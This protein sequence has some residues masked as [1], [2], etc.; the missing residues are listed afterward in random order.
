MFIG[1]VLNNDYKVRFENRINQWLD[2][3]K[4]KK[5]NVINI[6]QSGDEGWV[7]ISVFYEC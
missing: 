3:N 4:I 1:S 6:K 5:K 7:T 2:E